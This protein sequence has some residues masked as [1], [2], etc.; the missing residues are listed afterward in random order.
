[1]YG[2]IGGIAHKHGARFIADCDGEPLAYATQHDCDLLAPN[3]HEAERL[4]NE[5]IVS[6]QD[7]G[8]AARSLLSAAPAVLL[9]LGED[10]A[11]L[12]NPHGCWHARSR[13]LMHG[14]AV[15]AGDSFLAAYLLAEKRKAPPYEALREAV[16]AGTAVL[17]S[18]DKEILTKQDY[19]DV[20]ADVVVTPL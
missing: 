15:G 14:S 6:V 18:K 3:Q 2:L 10:G 11:V 19:D 5:V 1:V 20:L 4:L 7:A 17:L 13:A 8:T 12:A 16:A 9:K